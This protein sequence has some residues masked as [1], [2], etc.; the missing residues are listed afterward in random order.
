M[1][2]EGAADVIALG[3]TYLGWMAVFYALPALTNGFRAFT[4][5]WVR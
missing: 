4:A 1:W 2:Q 5:A 3:S